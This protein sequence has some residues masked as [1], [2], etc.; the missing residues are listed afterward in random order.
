MTDLTDHFGMA[1]SDDP[2]WR[3]YAETVLELFADQSLTL[4]LAR[5]IPAG[6]VLKLADHAIGPSFAVLTACNPYGRAVDDET[7]R[8]LTHE[9][10]AEMTVAGHVWAPADGVSRDRAHREPGVAVSMPKGD[11]RV[12]ATRYG[13]SAFFWFDGTRMWLV[14]AAVDSPD[15][16][17][18]VWQPGP[19]PAKDG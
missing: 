18:P 19:G 13:Q 1:P 11:A 15:I 10:R 7:N 8:R 3:Y 6:T 16:A 17:L 2:S 4:D 14:G 12:I 5:P 9:L